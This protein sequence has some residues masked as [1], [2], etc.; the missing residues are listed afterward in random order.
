VLITQQLPDDLNPPGDARP[1][2][3][4]PFEPDDLPEITF[5]EAIDGLGPLL[6]ASVEV[7]GGWVFSLA[8]YREAPNPGVNVYVVAPSERMSDAFSALSKSVGLDAND[9]DW[10]SPLAS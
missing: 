5:H 9:F 10:V 2:A 3:V 8:R 1:L 4:L 6:A 7:P